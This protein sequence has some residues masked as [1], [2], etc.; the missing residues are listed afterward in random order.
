MSTTASETAS[1][2]GTPA[3]TTEQETSTSA[4]EIEEDGAS[5]ELEQRRKRVRNWRLA[6]LALFVISSFVISKLTGLSHYLTLARMRELMSSAGG[7]GMA[8]FVVIF[9]VGELLHLP[10]F[11]FVGAS[12]MVYGKLGG[13][14][15]ALV[16]ATAS[17]AFSFLI[18]RGIGGKPMADIKRPLMKKMLARLDTQPFRTVLLLRLVFWM[19]PPLNYALALSNIKFRDYFVA[20]ALGLIL[21]IT[22]LVFVFQYFL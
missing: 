10:G 3:T 11:I 19:A 5:L 16:G 17:V 18:I 2:T 9:C 14:V 6:L 13:G 7:W 21:P 15:L 8:L 4:H 1:V 12:V 22:A 20:S